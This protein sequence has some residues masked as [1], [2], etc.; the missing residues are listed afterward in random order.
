MITLLWSVAS[1]AWADLPGPVGKWERIVIELPDADYAGNPFEIPVEAH[2]THDATGTRLVLP[3]YYAGESTWKIGFMPTL[4]GNWAFE[5]QSSNASLDGRSGA[6]ECEDSGRP[7]LL[8]ADP[9]H[10]RKWKLADGPHIVPIALRVEFFF[11][12][13]DMAD[14][15]DAV[16]FLVDDVRGHMYDTRLQDEFSGTMNVFDGN[17][18][19]LR[20]DLDT[21]DRMEAR[22]DVLAKRNAGAYIMFYADDDGRPRWDGRSY[23]EALLLRYAIARLAGYPIVMWDTGIDIDEYRDQRDIDWFGEQVRKLDPYGHP[24]SSRIGGGSGS[25]TMASR[26][27]DSRGDRR[28]II[29]DMIS[30][31]ERTTRPVAM[32]DSW[33]ENYARRPRKSFTPDDIRRAAWKSVMAGGQAIFLRGDDG[34]FHADTIREDLDSAVWLGLVNPFIER[35]LGP[36]F[37]A[38]VPERSLVSGGYCLADPA[39]DRLLY[40]ALGPNDSW[41]PRDAV[42]I[43]AVL[44]DLDGEYNAAWFDPRTGEDTPVG[45]L[46]AGASHTLPLPSKDDWVLL[47]TRTE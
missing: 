3:A 6:V 29:E 47:L 37:G 43:A 44:D 19:K 41:D 10:P 45:I 21:W 15:E 11:E 34:Y 22:M 42:E 39:R 35:R 13:A 24:V 30:Y 2:F 25:L 38:M 12:D 20:F 17:P 4:T 23:D 5:V 46:R 9:D 8:G 26:N 27:Y 36:H 32:A 7:G 14:W 40:Y 16:D 1:V 33:G 31:F 28:A 18:R